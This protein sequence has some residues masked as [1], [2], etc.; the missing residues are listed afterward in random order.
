MREQIQSENLK[1]DAELADM[2]LTV[3]KDRL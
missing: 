3:S 2:G 1:Y